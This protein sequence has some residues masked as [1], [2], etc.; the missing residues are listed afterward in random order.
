M[1]YFEP[2]GYT[3]GWG[4]FHISDDLFLEP[5]DYL[6]S[7]GH[8]YA[9]QHRFGQGPN[10]RLRTTRAALK[11]LGFRDELLR[12]G[13]QRQVF[14]CN[15]ASNATTIL[16]TGKG[17]PDL[18]ALLNV[19]QVADLALD[20]WILPRARRRPEYRLWNRSDV[21]RLLSDP[22]VTQSPRVAS[23]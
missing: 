4:H 18:S 9:D 16:R 13:V 5:R 1:R 2:I 23:R 21:L 20:R 8:R 22:V 11:A 6:R 14:I 12:H 17:R 3:R 7:I 19:Q 10:W 15:L